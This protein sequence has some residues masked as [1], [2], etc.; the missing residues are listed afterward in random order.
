M[1]EGW[2]GANCGSGR[3]LVLKAVFMG[4]GTE[5]W[6]FPEAGEVPAAVQ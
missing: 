5:G 4:G 3:I 1:G 2:P 6:C